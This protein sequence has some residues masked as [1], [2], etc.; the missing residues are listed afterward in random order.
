MPV[1][2]A[3]KCLLHVPPKLWV[4]AQSV[5]ISLLWRIRV[6]TALSHVGEA[7]AVP[8]LGEK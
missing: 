8:T 4:Y 5:L 1:K 3:K 2:D 6:I 7:D